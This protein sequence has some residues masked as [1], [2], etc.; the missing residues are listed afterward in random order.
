M[1]KN[2]VLAEG[3]QSQETVFKMRTITICFLLQGH[4]NSGEGKI[5]V[6]VKRI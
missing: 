2:G 1:E 4:R 3:R 6:G 5:D